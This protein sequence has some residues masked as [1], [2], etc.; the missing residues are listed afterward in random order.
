MYSRLHC[1]KLFV[2]FLRNHLCF[3]HLK[4]TNIHLLSKNMDSVELSKKPALIVE[5]PPGTEESKLEG[6]KYCCS[7]LSFSNEGAI[8]SYKLEDATVAVVQDEWMTNE[9]IK[10]QLNEINEAIIQEKSD[11]YVA[12]MNRFRFQIVI[13]VLVTLI[14][15]TLGVLLIF[16]FGP[17]A[18]DSEARCLAQKTILSC[19]VVTIFSFFGMLGFLWLV[20][21]A[22]KLANE[23]ALDEMR[24]KLDQFNLE[25][26]VSL[27][28][29]CKYSYVW[30]TGV[31]ETLCLGTDSDGD[32][33]SYMHELSL[34]RCHKQLKNPVT[35][36][37]CENDEQKLI[38]TTNCPIC[39]TERAFSP[40][41]FKL[42]KFCTTCR[43][44][45]DRSQ[46]EQQCI[47]EQTII[48]HKAN[49]DLPRE[50]RFALN[51]EPTQQRFCSSCGLLV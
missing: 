6:L 7:K 47:C 11:F 3:Q 34:L 19:T 51:R 40:H 30:S 13:L 15:A 27:P 36:T 1:E 48:Y 24:S 32:P 35:I 46:Q 25:H 41:T 26:E 16:F 23:A 8:T 50:V 14:I 12:N 20:S 2:V 9:M 10:G 28:V 49:P 21:N 44:Q 4:K 29:E 31:Q 45:F 33:K 18:S 37:F 17:C 42:G 5:I 39:R 43:F 22:N 38:P